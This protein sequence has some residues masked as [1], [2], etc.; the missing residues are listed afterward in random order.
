[1]ERESLPSSSEVRPQVPLGSLSVQFVKSHQARVE[2]QYRFETGSSSR[3]GRRDFVSILPVLQ[4][5]KRWTR[6]QR[7][8]EVLA[9]R[10]PREVSPDTALQMTFTVQMSLRWLYRNPCQ[11]RTFCRPRE[12]SAWPTPT[13]FSS[14]GVALD[15]CRCFD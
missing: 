13:C 5:G 14:F 10:Q 7:T 2:G 15:G 9:Y 8:G 1:V 6:G 11:R 3:A 12:T 4:V